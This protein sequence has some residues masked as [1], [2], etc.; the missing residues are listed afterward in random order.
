MVGHAQGGCLA[1]SGPIS[2]EFVTYLD[3]ADR[4]FECRASATG[5]TMGTKTNGYVLFGRAK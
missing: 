2:G 5:P 1:S 4:Y 3:G